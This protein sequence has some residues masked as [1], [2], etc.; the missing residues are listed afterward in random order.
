M[1]TKKITSDEIDQN[2][3]SSLPTRPTASVAFGGK[4]YTSAE[5]K[6]AFD[7][8]PKLIIERFN[9]LLSDLCDGQIL[10]DIPTDICD[11][12]SPVVNGVGFMSA[13]TINN[14]P[15]TNYAGYGYA[16][17]RQQTI[18]QATKPASD[19]LA[20]KVGQTVVHKNFGTGLLLLVKP[21][22]SDALLE[23]AFDTVGTKKLMAN[24]AGLK[25]L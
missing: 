3:V 8:L 22:S 6:E 23:I 4:G 14:A 20:Y 16:N 2:A 24:F 15:R 13:T 17:K 25:I 21:M 9:L 11:I 7:R 5:M 18:R 12:E 10:E 19:I 1:T